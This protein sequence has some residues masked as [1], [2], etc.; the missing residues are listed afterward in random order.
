MVEPRK[1]QRIGRGLRLGLYHLTVVLGTQ[2]DRWRLR[3]E[4]VPHTAWACCPGEASQLQVPQQRQRA[5]AVPE[6]RQRR[7]LQ[8]AIIFRT[9]GA[10]LE[11][12]PAFPVTTSPHATWRPRASYAPSQKAAGGSGSGGI[13]WRSAL[14][15]GTGSFHEQARHSVLGYKPPCCWKGRTY[16]RHSSPFTAVRFR[17]ALPIVPLIDPIGH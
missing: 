9:A 3:Q 10:T 13:P 2:A 4:A 8:T 1:D 7:G 17:R 5:R 14:K 11:L 16:S 15:T 12:H 6:E